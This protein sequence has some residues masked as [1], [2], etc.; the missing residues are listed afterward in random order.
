MHCLQVKQSFFANLL[1]SMM[2]C[3]ALILTILLHTVLGSGLIETMFAVQTHSNR[4]YGPVLES[5]SVRN[6]IVCASLCRETG[7][8][9]MSVV[10]KPS[11]QWNC[12][13]CDVVN[14]SEVTSDQY[15]VYFTDYKTFIGKEH[16][17]NSIL[18]LK[19]FFLWHI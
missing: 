6:K 12:E 8:H 18:L 10:K 15:L 16:L 17:C 4:R 1:I 7:C 3:Y 9:V 2:K 11:G 13:L 14:S 5:F 19:G